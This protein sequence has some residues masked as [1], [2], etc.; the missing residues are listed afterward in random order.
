MYADL[1][2][3]VSGFAD[4]GRFKVN[5]ETDSAK[6]YKGRTRLLCKCSAAGH[7]RSKRKRQQN[8]D[9][10]VDTLRSSRLVSK[11]R[12]RRRVSLKTGCPWRIVAWSNTKPLS[13]DT[14]MTVSVIHNVHNCN[15]CAEFA[16]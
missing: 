8:D 2:A 9:A 4:D 10:D 5:Y 16:G 12:L 14:L 11:A 13:D 7:A 3:K 15:S 6:K 1:R